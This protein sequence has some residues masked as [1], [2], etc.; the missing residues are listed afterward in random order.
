[1]PKVKWKIEKYRYPKDYASDLRDTETEAVFP[2]EAPG[3]VI[4]GEATHDLRRKSVV[5]HRAT[6]LIFAPSRSG[7]R[8]LSMAVE[9][10]VQAHKL[11]DFRKVKTANSF[12]VAMKRDPELCKKLKALR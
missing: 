1:M 5:L 8:S 9:V 7:Y 4:V 3:L 12:L 6:G 10:A 11:F 2:K